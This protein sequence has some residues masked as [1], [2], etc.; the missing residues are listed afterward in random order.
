[1]LLNRPVPGLN[2]ILTPRQEVS[3]F[4][5]SRRLFNESAP[6]GRGRCRHLFAPSCRLFNESALAPLCGRGNRVVGMARF[7]ASSPLA[8][9][10][11]RR[12]VRP[13]LLV[14]IGGGRLTLRPPRPGDPVRRDDAGCG[15][16]AS[17]HDC[18]GNSASPGKTLPLV[19]QPGNTLAILLP[20]STPTART[21][22]APAVAPATQRRPG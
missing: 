1:A 21:P 3:I 10:R 17:G 11:R 4:A 7:L 12:A 13:F 8:R 2:R 5:P 14:A 15:C 9:L 16:R 19:P 18:P 6:A 22:L 20:D